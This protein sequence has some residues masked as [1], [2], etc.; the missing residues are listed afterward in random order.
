MDYVNKRE[1]DSHIKLHQSQTHAIGGTNEV[2]DWFPYK[3]TPISN[4]FYTRNK[5]DFDCSL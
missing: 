2:G 5:K 3:I 4:I 1:I